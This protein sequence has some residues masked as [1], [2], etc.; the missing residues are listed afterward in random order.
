MT[1]AI[2]YKYRIIQKNIYLKNKWAEFKTTSD[3][4]ISKEWSKENLLKELRY[5]IILGFM[6]IHKLQIDYIID[7]IS[8][9]LV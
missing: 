3:W 1:S 2:I 5:K 9:R 8:K 4:F 6:N 7:D